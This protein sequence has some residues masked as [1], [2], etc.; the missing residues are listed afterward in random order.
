MKVYTPHRGMTEEQYLEEC[1]KRFR[2]SQDDT[3]FVV[4]LRMSQIAKQCHPNDPQAE[5]QFRNALSRL[6]RTKFNIRTVH[7]LQCTD[8]DDVLQFLDDI[9]K[10]MRR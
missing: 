1:R 5:Y 10:L 9:E 6:I 3:Q 2:E 8:K 7:F 4:S